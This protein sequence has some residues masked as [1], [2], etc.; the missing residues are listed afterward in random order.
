MKGAT[1]PKAYGAALTNRKL[2]EALWGPRE[3]SWTE[4][5]WEALE[6]D[7]RARQGLSQTLYEEE[8]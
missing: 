4:P 7:D 2:S 8:S 3:D 6:L 1:M 5:D